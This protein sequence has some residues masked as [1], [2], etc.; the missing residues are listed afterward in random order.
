MA[1]SRDLPLPVIQHITA[2]ARGRCIPGANRYARVARQWRDAGTSSD[3]AESLLQLYVD[4]R[5]MFPQHISQLSRW[6][7]MHGQHV[8]TLV[9]GASPASAKLLSLRSAAAALSNLTRLE[10]AQ[11]DSLAL[12]DHVMHQLPQLRHLAA[13]VGLMQRRYQSGMLKGTLVKDSGMFCIRNRPW[14]VLP[15]LDGLCPQLEHLQL[16]LEA[17]EGS[18]IYVDDDL[19]RMLPRGLQQLTLINTGRSYGEDAR[20]M[21]LR[22]TALQLGRFSA[23]QQLALHDIRVTAD[24]VEYLLK[25]GDMDMEGA[26]QGE[27]L[28]VSKRP[29][30]QL[31]LYLSYYRTGDEST[32]LQLAPLLTDLQVL[33]MADVQSLSD[34]APLTRLVLYVGPGGRAADALAALTGLRELD[35]GQCNGSD[36]AAAVEQA[37]GMPALRSLSVK[38]STQDPA[39]LSSSLGQCTQLTRLGLLSKVRSE[40]NYDSDS[41]E[42]S[43]FSED[44]SDAD[45]ADQLPAQVNTGPLVL[46]LQQLTGLRCLTVH[47]QLLEHEAGVWLGS[48]TALTRLCVQLPDYFPVQPRYPPAQ[49]DPD[50]W[51]EAPE[52]ARPEGA[53]LGQRN[54]AEARSLLQWV[55][56]WPASLQCV[57][58]WMAPVSYKWR[59]T[60]ICPKTWEH[61]IG[62]R[63]QRSIQVWLELPGEAADGWSRPFR[64][65]LH[66]Q[67]VWGLSS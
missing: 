13:H 12:L 37:A 60:L 2:L 63:A 52:G 29:L 57:V 45:D 59:H 64:P 54:E 40:D 10:V 19:D 58:F 14:K 32:L 47:P 49:P 27:K 16:T 26:D 4:Q 46:A 22:P 43:D 67:G 42:D 44:S 66:L 23:L 51:R 7:S 21:W 24:G 50:V 20:P 55:Q 36:L 31:Q 28:E 5:W 8:G 18:S 25:G 30:L 62:G 56:V 11:R 9:I 65:C 39:A 41:A 35:L 6:M 15:E 53:W 33:R 38:G 3:D 34:L 48:L 1:P 17:I 61:S